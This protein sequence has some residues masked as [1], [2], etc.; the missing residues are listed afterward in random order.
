MISITINYSLNSDN[1]EINT[2]EK[3][4]NYK[5][6][7]SAIKILCK[8]DFLNMLYTLIIII[9]ILLKTI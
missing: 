8:F 4:F 9:Y 7:G 1:I 6:C 2:L 3:L 5:I